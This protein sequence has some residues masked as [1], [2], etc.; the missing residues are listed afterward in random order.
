[1]MTISGT[2][3]CMLL[4]GLTV[5]VCGLCAEEF[6]G[7]AEWRLVNTN[8]VAAW[9]ASQ[10]KL[11]SPALKAWPGVV[12]DAQKREVRLLAEAVGHRAGITTE[13]LLVGPASDRAGT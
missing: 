4:F 1:M 2:K 5:A 13:F 8:A 6:T 3:R 10:Q 11:A 7:P 9:N 12:A